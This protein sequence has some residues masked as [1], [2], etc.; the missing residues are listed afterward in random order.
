MVSGHKGMGMGMGRGMGMGMDDSANEKRG[1]LQI[2]VANS[3][4]SDGR[5]AR[6]IRLVDVE[7]GHFVGS[8]AHV[9][10]R[11]LEGVGGLRRGVKEVRNDC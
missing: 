5:G 6:R 4:D 10:K 1:W 8:G 3:T 7:D 11:P 2:V 9:L